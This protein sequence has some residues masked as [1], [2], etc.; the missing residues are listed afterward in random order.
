M[1]IACTAMYV[2]FFCTNAC[3]IQKNVVLRP[4]L[5]HSEQG[6]IK[7]SMFV[8]R[9]YRQTR[10]AHLLLSM[11]TGHYQVSLN[12]FMKV[13][14]PLSVGFVSPTAFPFRKQKSTAFSTCK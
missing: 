4:S 9:S 11:S 3:T 8:D 2:R 5:I 14:S 1:K 10:A 6:I 7:S 13:Q 12:R